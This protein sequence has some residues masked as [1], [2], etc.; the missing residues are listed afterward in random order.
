MRP[1]AVAIAVALL[2]SAC[3]SNDHSDIEPAFIP[4]SDVEFIDSMVAHHQ[5]A[6]D[7]ANEE[8]ARGVSSEVKAMAQEMIAVQMQEIATM[9]AA[10]RELTGDERGTVMMDPHMDV[11]MGRF[12]GIGGAELDR[13]FLEEMIAHHAGALQTSHRALPNLTRNDMRALA[14]SMSESQAR[15]IGDMRTMLDAMTSR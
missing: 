15:E 5:M 4:A 12:N 7:M 2:S 3:S 10:R 13:R 9:R 6:I 14:T 8:V 11:D 1:V